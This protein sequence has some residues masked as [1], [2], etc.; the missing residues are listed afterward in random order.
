M[1][2]PGIIDIESGN[3]VYGTDSRSSTTPDVVSY[4]AM[5][6]YEDTP[7]PFV[8]DRKMYEDN[9]IY[10]YLSFKQSATLMMTDMALI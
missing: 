8:A 5:D 9:L 3:R 6:V 4:G 1:R 2:G 10:P 7:S